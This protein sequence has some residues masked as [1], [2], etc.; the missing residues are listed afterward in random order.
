MPATVIACS[1]PQRSMTSPLSGFLWE[2]WPCTGDQGTRLPILG[3]LITHWSFSGICP[4]TSL[5]KGI[6]PCIPEIGLPSRG[7]PCQAP[8]AE[9]PLIA[10]YHPRFHAFY[11]VGRWAVGL[12]LISFSNDRYVHSRNSAFVASFILGVNLGVTLM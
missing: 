5:Q 9:G 2:C 7:N 1:P 12:P 4:P 10:D 11:Q 6:A 8:V 3:T